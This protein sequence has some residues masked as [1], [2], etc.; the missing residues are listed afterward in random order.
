MRKFRGHRTS[1][2][3]FHTTE[4]QVLAISF[5]L[6][7]GWVASQPPLRILSLPLQHNCRASPA[8]NW[9]PGGSANPF[10]HLSQ[11]GGQTKAWT[12]YL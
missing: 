11:K 5:S 7:G 10:Q 8:V 9:T 1:E 4:N 2:V 12:Q 6:S 3:P